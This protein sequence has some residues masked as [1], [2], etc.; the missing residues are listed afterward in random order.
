MNSPAAPSSPPS[1]PK[2]AVVTVTGRTS[3]LTSTR[4]SCSKNLGD[5]KNSRLTRPVTSSMRSH[6]AQDTCSPSSRCCW[7]CRAVD[8]ALT[9]VTTAIN[10][11]TGTRVARLAVPRSAASRA[12]TA[13]LLA[14]TSAVAITAPRI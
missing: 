4:L 9:A 1:S 14:R 3:E 11:M 5:S 7:A 8:A 10:R 2:I 6:A 12:S 13:S